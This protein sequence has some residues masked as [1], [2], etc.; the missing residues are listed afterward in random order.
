VNPTRKR[1]EQSPNPELA[2]DLP[3]Q[4]LVWTPELVERFWTGISQTRL[5]EYDFARQGGKS[6][7]I[8]VEHHLPKDGR[9]LDFGAG[10]GELVE[11]LLERGYQ[12]AA[13]EPSHGRAGCLL[14]HLGA[15]EGFLGVLG[16][17][18]KEQFDAVLMVEVIEHIL[19]EEFDRALRRVHG[20][21]K[22][23]GILIVTTPN[24][25]D[26]ELGMTYCP[27]SNMLFHRWQHVRSFTAESL[28]TV[29][30]HY[31]IS[32]IV[33][34]YLDLRPELYVPY[35]HRWGGEQFNPVTPSHLTAIR[36][37]IS[38]HNGSESNLLYIGRKALLTP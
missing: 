36:N 28:S 24:N 7:I 37:N 9:I 2:Q 38:V 29:L 18:S 6:L 27:A 19:D 1:D 30:S 5:T 20:M 34:H 4:R 14:N 26:L 16:P 10:N 15:R 25:E 17:E 21:L 11:L 8:A 33:I 3:V 12:V 31:G 35:D 13:Y 32:P 22:E 23:A